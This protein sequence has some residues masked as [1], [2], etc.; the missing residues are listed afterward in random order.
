VPSY[1][2][3]NGTTTYPAPSGSGRPSGFSGYP[4]PSGSG[5]PGSSGFISVVKPTHSPIHSHHQP[6]HKP[7]KSGY[8][9][10]PFF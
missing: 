4:G 5:Y 10:Y 3:T 1:P 8:P 7:T 6:S 2:Y 9:F